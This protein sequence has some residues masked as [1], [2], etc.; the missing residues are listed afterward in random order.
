MK[1]IFYNNFC[2]IFRKNKFHEENALDLNR[3]GSEFKRVEKLLIFSFVQDKFKFE[4]RGKKNAISCLLEFLVT[5][6]ENSRKTFFLSIH[7]WY[8][9]QNANLH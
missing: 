5:V 6:T 9:M 7:K 1:N 4:S 3:F 8:F 2:R